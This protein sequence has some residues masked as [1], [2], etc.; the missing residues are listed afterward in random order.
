M[1]I[2]RFLKK[3]RISNEIE[4]GNISIHL[5]ELIRNGSDVNDFKNFVIN[6]NNQILDN[7]EKDE[8][9]TKKN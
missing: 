1:G 3:S 2:T 9:T 4:T 8:L 6:V 7:E 5:N